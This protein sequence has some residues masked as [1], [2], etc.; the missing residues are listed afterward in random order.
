[1]RAMMGQFCKQLS[2]GKGWLLPW[3]GYTTILVQVPPLAV[4]TAPRQAPL[5]LE[6]QRQCIASF[7]CMLVVSA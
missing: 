7:G 1:M 5:S 6:R 3:A 4:E 2:E